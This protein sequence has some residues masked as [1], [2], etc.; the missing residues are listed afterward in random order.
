MG[1]G[2]YGKIKDVYVRFKM[3]RTS[4]IFVLGVWT[5]IIKGLRLLTPAAI[6]DLVSLRLD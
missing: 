5:K 2:M 4:A 6:F 1:Q 3:V